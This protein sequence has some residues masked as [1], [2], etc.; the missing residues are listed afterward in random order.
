MH[1]STA[2]ALAACGV[3]GVSKAIG[4]SYPVAHR[5][6][7][8]CNQI[9]DTCSGLGW[10]MEDRFCPGLLSSTRTCTYIIKRVEILVCS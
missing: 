10:M 9:L 8:R 6:G 1:V 2:S 3:F 4:R 7:T 5:L